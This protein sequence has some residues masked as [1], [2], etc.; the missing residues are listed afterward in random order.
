MNGRHHLYHYHSKSP[1]FNQ[2]ELSL[3]N[4]Y[5]CSHIEQTLTI[6]CAIDATLSNRFTFSQ[7]NFKRVMSINSLVFCAIIL[8]LVAS[9][10]NAN[11]DCFLSTKWYKNC[12]WSNKSTQKKPFICSISSI[13][14]LF[15]FMVLSV[16]SLFTPKWYS[17][18]LRW[19]K[20]ADR[21]A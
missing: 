6:S 14:C 11:F 16:L 12:F 8:A 4:M 5:V 9:R 18:W 2:Q 7:H 21:N 17:A 3:S 10:A 19:Y 20:H 15:T 13:T 1:V